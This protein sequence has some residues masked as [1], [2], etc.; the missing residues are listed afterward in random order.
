MPILTVVDLPVPPS[1]NRIWRQNKAGKRD[2]PKWNARTYQMQARVRHVIKSELYRKWIKEANALAMAT[3][4]LKGV[5][6]IR[7]KF[8]A[9]IV[10][11]C[12]DL[13]RD[14][15]FDIDNRSK[16]VLDWAQA[17]RLIEN[18]RFCMEVTVRW[19]A[20][21][22]APT[23]A[24]LRLLQWKV[25]DAPPVANEGNTSGQANEKPQAKPG[26]DSGSAQADTD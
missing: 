8:T 23:G 12:D 17:Q 20:R 11:A 26:T 21:W 25:P 2:V 1:V 16:G 9:L 6:M 24:R 19:G 5:Q 3:G 13:E 14:P 4:A 22:E 10:I 15:P 7:G 18:D